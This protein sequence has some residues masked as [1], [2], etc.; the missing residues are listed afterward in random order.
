MNKINLIHTYIIS[1]IVKLSLD[2]NYD[3]NSH[4]FHC[5]P[6]TYLRSTS[7]MHIKRLYSGQK[8]RLHISTVSMLYARGRITL[9]ARSITKLF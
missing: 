3:I 9:L 6:S 5:I 7:S 8:H 1:F 4:N 2:V